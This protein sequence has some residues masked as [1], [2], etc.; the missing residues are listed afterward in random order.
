MRTIKTVTL[1]GANGTM[2]SA[3]AGIIAG[4][5]GAKIFMLA[6]T[7]EKADEGIKKA[8]DSIKSESILSQLI[9]KTYDELG[10]CVMESDFVLECVSEN[11]AVKKELNNQ[12]AKCKKP[13]TIVAT[14][15]SGFSISEL[16]SSFSPTEEKNYFGVHFFNPPYK[17]LLCELISTN[18]ANPA[19][20]ND[21]NNYLTNTLRRKVVETTDTPGFAG[22]RVG[23]Q[24]LNEAAQFA[25]KYLN[26]GGVGY[27]D[28]I[29][30]GYTGRTMPPLATIDLIGLDTHQAI[31]DYLFE[32]TND[33]AHATF[34]LPDFI[35]ALISEGKLGNK[36]GK[37]LYAA[38]SQNSRT[39]I[40]DFIE[41]SK[42]LIKV[43]LY[44]EAYKLIL[45][46]KT[47]E[48][49]IVRYF[50]ARYISYSLNL[51]GKV[52]KTKEEMDTVM[53]YGF[54]WL[55]PCALVD[56]LGHEAAVNLI[57]HFGFTVPNLL[58]TD[59]KLY[60]LQPTLD[61]R[62]YIKSY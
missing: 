28:A 36:T 14:I 22:N 26:D 39:Y 1:F 17:M 62:S 27:I 16:S 49:E 38:N 54:G 13:G 4:F 31:V 46:S 51:V 47:K 43:G 60:T 33:E 20:K 18:Q 11:I 45:G 37:G 48:S 32:K 59:K 50:W 8:V 52:V 10:K 34:R 40:F 6:R 44:A 5:G 58:D 2:G 30:G 19:T 61:Y 35:K 7:M 21:L 29:L 56:L 25:E 41:E 24:I 9:P 23:L 57:K 12:I 55:P 53:A 15:S 3:S 42:E